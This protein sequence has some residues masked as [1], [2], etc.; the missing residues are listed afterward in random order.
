MAS[1]FSGG[2]LTSTIATIS[3]QSEKQ[4]MA[5]GLDP[6][7]PLQFPDVVE[8]ATALVGME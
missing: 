3:R 7:W 4:R 5:E 8:D 6:N 2:E 1:L